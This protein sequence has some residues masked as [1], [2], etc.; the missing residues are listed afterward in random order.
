MSTEQHT[1]G[2]MR[3]TG[4]RRPARAAFLPRFRGF[5]CDC[6]ATVAIEFAFALPILCMLVFA[7]YEVTQGVI[8]YMKVVD[9]ANTV[10]DL[11]GQISTAQGGV[12]NQDFDDYYIAG[13]LVMYPSTGTNLALAVT[14]VYYN[15]TGAHPTVAWS[16]E[17]GGAAAISSP[18]SYVSGLGTANGSTIIVQATY[19][20]TSLLDYFI[21]SPITI[22]SE[23]TSQPRNFLPGAGYDQGIP[24][25]PPSGLESCN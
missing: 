5:L 20:Y 9:V 25:P 12:G 6:R 17:R 23:V 13:E 10:S 14:S 4:P 3:D 11:I 18:T 2:T 8:T 22:T 24:C 21:T 1:A 7:L 15:S 19:T 16:V